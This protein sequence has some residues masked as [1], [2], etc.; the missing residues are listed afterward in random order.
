MTFGKPSLSTV[1][2]EYSASSR[3][4]LGQ[5]NPRRQIC[6]L[7]TT[8]PPCLL[9]MSRYTLGVVERAFSTC[10]Y[11]SFHGTCAV[12]NSGVSGSPSTSV[13]YQITAT[14]PGAPPRTHGSTHVLVNSNPATRGALRG[15]CFVHLTNMVR[16]APAGQLTR[17]PVCRPENTMLRSAAG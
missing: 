6:P 13:A 17:Q 3:V 16:L 11:T 9:A 8:P 4:P 2:E 12:S 5:P 14:F 10:A 15:T 1:S 7:C